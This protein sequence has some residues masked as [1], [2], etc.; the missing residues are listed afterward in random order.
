MEKSAGLK[1][2]FFGFVKGSFSGR[3]R[4][5]ELSSKDLQGETFKED[6]VDCFLFIVTQDTAWFM[7]LFYS[8]QVSVKLNM[9]CPHSENHNLIFSFQKVDRVIFIWSWD[10]LKH[11]SPLITL[12]PLIVPVNCLV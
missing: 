1:Q 4:G 12:C 11:H 10:M 9:I 3:F 6:M 8:A 7:V 2:L 5:K